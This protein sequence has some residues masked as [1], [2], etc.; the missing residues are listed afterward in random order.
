MINLNILLFCNILIFATKCADWQ[1]F[2]HANY[3]SFSVLGHQM[4]HRKIDPGL[5]VAILV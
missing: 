4:Y 5:E 3:S 2:L 1:E